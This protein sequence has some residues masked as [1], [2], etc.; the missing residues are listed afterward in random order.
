[1]DHSGKPIAEFEFTVSESF[2][3]RKLQGIPVVMIDGNMQ[4]ADDATGYPELVEWV[5]PENLAVIASDR[6]SPDSP[7]TWLAKV[8]V[9]PQVAVGLKL[10]ELAE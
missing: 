9:P 7:G 10:K 3:G 2:L 4:E 1:M 5:S 8:L 6:L